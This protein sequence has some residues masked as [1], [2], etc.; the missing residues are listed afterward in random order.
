M[1]EPGAGLRAVEVG[2]RMSA[3]CYS[4]S[5]GGSGGVKVQGGDREGGLRSGL[6]N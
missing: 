1:E 2:A 6:W 3:C 4:E 5:R